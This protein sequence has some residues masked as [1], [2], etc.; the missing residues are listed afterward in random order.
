MANMSY[1]ANQNTNLD[2]RQILGMIG[3]HDTIEDYMESLSEDESRAF[4][5]IVDKCETIISLIN[6]MGC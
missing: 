4:D 2:L 5:S 6:D 1:C 3:E